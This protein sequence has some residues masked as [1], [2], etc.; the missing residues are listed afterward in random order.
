MS[1]FGTG[2]AW[3]PRLRAHPL[4]RCTPTCHAHPYATTGEG[5]QKRRPWACHMHARG[6]TRTSQQPNL[7]V[8]DAL[9]PPTSPR[10]YPGVQRKHESIAAIAVSP[11][12][13][14]HTQLETTVRKVLFVDP[15]PNAYPRSL[16]RVSACGT[17]ALPHGP[18][19]DGSERWQ[20]LDGWR[21][22]RSRL[23]LRRPTPG[24]LHALNAPG[25]P[26]SPPP[27]S[28]RPARRWRTPCRA[29]RCWP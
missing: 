8:N 27:A 28:R 1:P 5:E 18:S 20:R 26:S 2:H 24:L 3:R 22:H 6:P 29:W 7:N 25:C 21:R 14:I 19:G 15:N 11:Y 17:Q 4:G 13:V 12:L 23:K 10:A 16:T 9:R